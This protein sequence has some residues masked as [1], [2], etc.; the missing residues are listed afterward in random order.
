MIKK[1][2]LPLLLLLAFSAQAAELKS[3][4]AHTFMDQ[5][6]KPQTLNEQTEWLILSTH[7]AGGEWVKKALSDLKIQDLAAKN[8]LYVADISAMPSLITR[9]VAIPKMQDYTFA[10]ALEK[11]GEV[12][13]NWPKQ[14]D[15]VSVYKLKGLQIEEVHTLDSEQAVLNFIKLI[16]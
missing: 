4:Q 11:E 10:I 2:L 7:K 14:A 12:T 13:A 1:I 9:F 5:W 15:K 8:W 3:L 16:K 6:D